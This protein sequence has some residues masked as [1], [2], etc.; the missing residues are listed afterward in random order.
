MVESD[1]MQG[2]Q[3]GDDVGQWPDL[4]G[5]DH[6]TYT[7]R[8][9]RGGGGGQGGSSAQ[10]RKSRVKPHAPQRRTSRAPAQTS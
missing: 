1:L 7:R 5:S 8:H 10:Q 2:R 3:S 9:Q 4:C 6:E